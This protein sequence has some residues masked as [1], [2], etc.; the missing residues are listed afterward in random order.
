LFSDPFKT[1]TCILQA[2]YIIFNGE[3]GGAYSNH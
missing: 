3:I 2:Y 1:H